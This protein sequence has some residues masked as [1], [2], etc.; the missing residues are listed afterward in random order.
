MS[1]YDPTNPDPVYQDEYG[2]RL[3]RSAMIWSYVSIGAAV[4]AVVLA[5]VAL[6]TG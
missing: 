2:R 6:A 5:V 4:V 1:R 3:V